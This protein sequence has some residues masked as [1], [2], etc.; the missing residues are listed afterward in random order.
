MNI[1]NIWNYLS[2]TKKLISKS[3]AIEGKLPEYCTMIEPPE[4]PEGKE[5]FFD[6][7]N[8]SW[9]L[10]DMTYTTLPAQVVKVYGYAPDTLIYIGIA[11]AQVDSLPP[12]CTTVEPVTSPGEGYVLVF[13]KT[14]QGWSVMED[15]I[16]ETVYSIETSQP[17]YISTPGEYPDETTTIAPAVPFPVWNGSE[18]VTD[19]TAQANSN[20]Q[21]NV[22]VYREL[23]YSVSLSLCPLNAAVAQSQMLTTDQQ[24]TLNALQLFAVELAQ[25]IQTA[26][27]TQ[28]DL[29][30]PE[31]APALIAYPFVLNPVYKAE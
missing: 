30:F 18:W 23:M 26:D 28:S 13:D 31:I 9:Y 11:D 22:S 27:L 6:E 25:F 20:V 17:V 24:D 3:N 21:K 14:A 5:A 8:Q 19:A 1:V 15:H 4:I 12:N 2:D 7:T 16:G 10:Q 29:V